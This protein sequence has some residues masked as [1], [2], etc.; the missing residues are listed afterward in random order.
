MVRCV[1]YIPNDMCGLLGLTLFEYHISTNSQLY[2]IWS[3]ECKL[4]CW[5]IYYS[6]PYSVMEEKG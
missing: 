5:C 3:E 6:T 4:H 1:N 2:F